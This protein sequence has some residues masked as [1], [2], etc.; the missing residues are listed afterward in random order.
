MNTP[1]PGTT[2]AYGGKGVV[3]I[4]LATGDKKV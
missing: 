3:V 4:K 2:Y 1:N